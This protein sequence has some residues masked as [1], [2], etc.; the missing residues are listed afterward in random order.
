MGRQD[1][2][3]RPRP[4]TEMGHGG[5]VLAATSFAAAYASVIA[6]FVVVV[7]DGSLGPRDVMILGVATMLASVV[8]GAL[9]WR[10]GA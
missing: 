4:R 9:W 5:L 7:L 1:P 10:R 6:A 8:V 2:G 3:R